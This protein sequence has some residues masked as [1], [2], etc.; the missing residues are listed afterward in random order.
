MAESPAQVGL[1]QQLT[2]FNLVFWIA[3]T[4]EM[5]ERLAYYGLRTVLPVYMVLAVE[6]GGPEFSHEQKGMI[7]MWWAWV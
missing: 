4:M 2:S 3:N 1:W 6:S 7:F 5:L